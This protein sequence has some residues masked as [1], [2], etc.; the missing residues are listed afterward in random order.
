[1]RHGEQNTETHENQGGVEILVVLLHVFGVIPHRLSVVHRVEI[2][3]GAVGWLEIH[4]Q[5][6]LNVIC[7][8]QPAPDSASLKRTTEGRHWPVS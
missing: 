7:W 3:V 1:M 8:V 2:E 6:L 4:S 5:S